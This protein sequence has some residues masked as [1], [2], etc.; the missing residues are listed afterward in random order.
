MDGPL[1]ALPARP[2]RGRL[3]RQGTRAGAVPRPLPSSIPCSWD[4]S[5]TPP[6]PAGPGLP[7]PRTMQGPQKHHSDTAG[8]PLHG[9]LSPPA[10]HT[11]TL[12]SGEPTVPRSVG[13]QGPSHCRTR[14]LTPVRFAANNPRGRGT[15]L[16]AGR[17]QSRSRRQGWGR[18]EGRGGERER[19]QAEK[20]A[21]GVRWGEGPGARKTLGR[22]T[23]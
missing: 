19:R 1:G 2:S 6:L 5:A 21:E 10:S 16:R 4:T 11:H 15:G 17:G 3:V 9:G 22:P 14:R 12:R 20:G 23:G 8:C 13:T 18:R 7:S